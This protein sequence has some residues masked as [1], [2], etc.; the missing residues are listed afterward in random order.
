MMI[1]DKNRFDLFKKRINCALHQIELR[2]LRPATN[3]YGVIRN[4]RNGNR[5]TREGLATLMHP[6]TIFIEGRPSLHNGTL[7]SAV[8]HCASKVLGVEMRSLL[9]FTAGLKL[10]ERP[11]NL[12]TRQR[13]YYNFGTKVRDGIDTRKQ[14]RHV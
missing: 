5:F 14:R 1:T 11:M 3:V 6:F 8:I 10:A 13:L 4:R 12:T 9:A 2:G 7:S